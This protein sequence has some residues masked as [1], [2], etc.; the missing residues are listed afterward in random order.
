MVA[1]IR[2]MIRD[3]YDLTLEQLDDDIAGTDHIARLAHA[4]IDTSGKVLTD[5]IEDKFIPTLQSHISICFA[6]ALAVQKLELKTDATAPTRPVH[7]LQLD[8]ILSQLSRHANELD[9]TGQ[10]I[11]KLDTAKLEAATELRSLVNDME[12]GTADSASGGDS[13]PEDVL[14]GRNPLISGIFHVRQMI[15]WEYRNRYGN[16]IFLNLDCCSCICGHL[17]L[18]QCRWAP[19]YCARHTVGNFSATP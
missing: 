11:R 5:I 10:T 8:D 12:L 1:P 14:Q 7:L 18:D 3:R 15:I 17:L 13:S 6:R 16:G 9:T 2:E 4:A 19:L